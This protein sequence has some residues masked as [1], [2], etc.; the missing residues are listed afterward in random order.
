MPI[1]PEAPPPGPFRA[2]FWKSPLRGP[3][4]SSLL[5]TAM[6]PLFL[7]CMVT[8]YL[9]HAAYDPGLGHNSV[10]SGG[11]VPYFFHWPTHPAWLYAATQGIHIAAGIALA[12]VLLAKLWSVIPKLFDWPAVRSPAHAIERLSIALLVASSLFTLVSGIFNSEIFYPWRFSFVPV[13]YYAAILFT[14]SLAFHVAVKFKVV[15]QAFRDRGLIA[16][17]RESLAETQPEPPAH[18]TTAPTAPRPPTIS[19]RGFVGT[20]GAASLAVGVSAAGQSVGGPL[21]ELAIFAPRGR[22]PRPGPNGFQVNKTAAAVGVTAAQTGATW[23][24]RVAGPD[25]RI[26]VFSRAALLALTQATEDLPIACVEGWSTTQRWTG[27]P[28]RTLAGLVGAGPG[29]LLGVQSLQQRGE[30]RQTTLAANQADD[31]RSLLALRVNGVDLSI[32]HGFPARIIVPAL[33]GVHCTKWVSML[34]FTAA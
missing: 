20:V 2:E 3:W 16:P 15:R 22:V 7:L 29:H 19:R 14:V 17:L 27:V 5:G 4:L 12:P 6:L 23:S 32:D 10:S 8:G 9:S 24:L 28:L 18:D 1:L 31:D 21:R 26:R 13:H 33:P 11:I 34:E 25:G 30:F